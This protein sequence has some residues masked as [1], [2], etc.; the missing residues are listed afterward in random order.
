[1]LDLVFVILHYI[2]FDDTL[3]CVKSIESKVD[4]EYYNIIVVD[5]G[6]PNGTFA[7]LEAK[8]SGNKRI[9]LIQ[10]KTN[11]GFA[12]GNNVGIDYAI[13][14][15]EFKFMVVLN[16]DT[17]L[18]DREFFKI[19]EEKYNL[20]NFAVMGP[21][22]LTKDGMCSTNPICS[23]LASKQEVLSE[24]RHFS[25]CRVLNTLHVYPL[26]ELYLTFKK[27]IKAK[28]PIDEPKF[29]KDQKNVRLNG[30]CLIFSDKYFE[31]FNG[32]DN[33][34]FMYF[35]EAI[36]QLHLHKKNLISLYSPDIKLYHKEC[37]STNNSGNNVRDIVE[38]RCKYRLESR[39][40]YLDILDSYQ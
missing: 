9:K 19:I 15:L 22:I 3:E 31:H 12:R 34:T 10:S 18:L 7:K 39:E 29:L 38:F 40:K 16:N 36:L 8:Y 37:A 13:S 20:T 28:K 11:L 17:C 27:I 23:T 30:C 2:T 24:I 4:T 26:Y 6:S 1:M 5:N 21:M 14:N 25:R 32:L 33:S 35:E